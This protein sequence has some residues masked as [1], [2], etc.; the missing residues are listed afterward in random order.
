V[1]K[2]G[3]PREWQFV[4]CP[5]NFKPSEFMVRW[6]TYTGDTTKGIHTFRVDY[7]CQGANCS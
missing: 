7:C 5:I 2:G 4:M 1:D 3:S 6:W